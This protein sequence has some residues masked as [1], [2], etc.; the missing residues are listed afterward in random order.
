MQ[1][2]TDPSPV[3]PGLTALVMLLRFNGVGAEPGQIRHRFG[4]P[5]IGV[6]Q[7]LRC[8]RELGLKARNPAEMP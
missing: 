5:Q 1:Q 6:P 4:T 8:A 3:G 2:S 7:M